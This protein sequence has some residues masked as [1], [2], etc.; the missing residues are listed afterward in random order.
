[1]GLGDKRA[2]LELIRS[3]WDRRRS[4]KSPPPLLWPFGPHA[5]G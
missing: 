4:V 5:V 3:V 2:L 1:M